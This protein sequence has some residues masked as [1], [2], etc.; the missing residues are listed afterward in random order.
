MTKIGNFLKWLEMQGVR[1]ATG[2]ELEILKKI[3]DAM[4]EEDKEV[5]FEKLYG[6]EM[7]T[8]EEFSKYFEKERAN[9]KMDLKKFDEKVKNFYKKYTN[10]FFDEWLSQ[11]DAELLNKLGLAMVEEIWEKF[12]VEI[13]EGA[14]KWKLKNTKYY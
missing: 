4:D 8:F 10:N 2:D 6:V 7:K 13:D 1:N 3:F 11:F 5:E 9:T 12:I 14:G